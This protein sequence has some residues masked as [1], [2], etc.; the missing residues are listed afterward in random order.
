MS[1]LQDLLQ[2]SAGLHDHLCPRQ[3]LGVRTGLL[4]A[5]L[6][7]FDLP[8]SGKRLFAFVETDGC[9]ADGLSVATGCWLGHRTLRLVDCGKV[10]ATLVDTHDGKALRIT[11]HPAARD[12][13]LLHSPAAADPWHAQLEAYQTIPDDD[14]LQVQAV[15][16][17]VSLESIISRPGLRVEC[18]I[19]GEEI[20]NEREVWREGRPLCRQCAG[21]ESYYCADTP[22]GPL[23][24]QARNAAWEEGHE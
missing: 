3:V 19:C 11:P 17:S 18:T 12:H 2:K 13:A 22:N 20:M 23:D 14:L 6:F 9:Y 24:L 15:R 5:R 10:A 21:V 4:A 1:D 16:L 7:G 8:Q